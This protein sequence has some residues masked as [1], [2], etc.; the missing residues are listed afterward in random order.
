MPPVIEALEHWTYVS[1][2]IERARRFYVDV[3]GAEALDRPGGAPPAV[4]V[5]G[6]VIDFF[7][8][9]PEWVPAPGTR[10]QHHALRI[11]LED[12]DTWVDHL[13]DHNVPIELAC[14]GPQ[15][16]SIYLQDPDGYHLELTLAVDAETGRREIEKR[17]IRRYSIP[18]GWER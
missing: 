1:S 16:M 2:D 15:R 13:R 14:H 3:L 12:Y 4:T 10:G 9:S 5:A 7:P 17:G 11:R 6:N 18:G 8:A